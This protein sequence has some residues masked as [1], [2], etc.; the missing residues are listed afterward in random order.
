[1]KGSAGEIYIDPFLI[2]EKVRG[3]K[4]EGRYTEA[5]YPT[6][7]AE[8]VNGVFVHEMAHQINHSE[9]EYHAKAMTDL[10]GIL[11]GIGHTYQRRIRASFADNPTSH[12]DALERLHNQTKIYEDSNIA[13]TL[14]GIG[15]GERS[16]SRGN[17]SET[18]SRTS[19]EN[20]ERGYEGTEGESRKG[21]NYQESDEPPAN[22]LDFRPKPQAKTYVESRKTLEETLNSPE[23]KKQGVI[24][25][26]L[27][28]MDRRLPVF[29]SELDKLAT[30]GGEAGKYIAPHIKEALNKYDEF[31]GRWLNPTLATLKSHSVDDQNLI[32]GTMREENR[33]QV[34]LRDELP[35]EK[36]KESYDKIRQLLVDKQ[37]NQIE[38]NQPVDSY[39]KGKLGGFKT[40]PRLP[41]INKFYFPDIAGAKQLDII[42]NS[43]GSKAFD[44]LKR[45]FI[46]HIKEQ[47]KFDDAAAEQFFQDYRGSYSGNQGSGSRKFGAVNKAEG[48]GLPDSWLE[49]DAKVTMRRYW[50]RVSKARSWYDAVE[51]DHN[52]LHILNKSRDAWDEKVTPTVEGLGRGNQ[53]LTD[54]ID[55]IN[56][57]NIKT[58]PKL[59]ATVRIANNLLMGFATGV[60]DVISA[61]PVASK[62]LPSMFD[63][64]AAMGYAIKNLKRSIQH[65]TE[66]GRIKDKISDMQEIVNPSTDV[67]EKLRESA[68][69]V[70]KVT[71]REGLEKFS[72][73]LSQGINEYA[74]Q[75]HKKL[76]EL[77]DKKSIALLEDIANTS[78]WK[79]M[80]LKQLASRLVDRS[81]GTYDVRGLPNWV[82][83][84]QVSPLFR[85][86]KWNIEQL[87][88]LHKDVIMPA[89]RG[90]LTPLITTMV[91]GIAGGYIAKEVREA[92]N[93]KEFNGPNL[94]EIYKSKGSV[95]DKLHGSTY[96]VAAAISYSGVM[97]YLGELMKIGM[98]VSYKNKPHGLNFPTVEVISDM[99]DNISDAIQAITQ[100]GENPATVFPELAKRLITNNIQVG[101]IASNWLQ[102]KDTH[103][104]IRQRRDLR[105]YK[106]QAGDSYQGQT[107]TSNVN[108]YIGLETKKFQ[109]MDDIKEI[110]PE[111]RRLVKQTFQE[112]K[113]NPVELKSKMAKL[114]A[115]AVTTFPSVDS[116]PAEFKKYYNY[117]VDLHGPEEASKR[118]KEYF[119]KKNINN[120]RKSLIPTI[121]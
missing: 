115:G 15:R 82:I 6:A 67:V 83:N 11:E 61:M 26:N 117:L 19:A 108:P 89:T 57:T 69:F 14:V 3:S 96:A 41:R 72:R 47:Y 55:T 99:A 22:D 76:A 103:N 66:T 109:K 94:D 37:Q 5:E 114:K 44:I 17:D 118:M 111:S 100:E 4:A 21:K 95:G 16:S 85:M 73:G 74:V 92:I 32:V 51:K 56:G 116:A 107:S 58:N 10:A 29:G 88:N 71:G 79:S 81:Q 38:A 45:D 31:I 105:V 101:R 78:D 28:S 90:N 87:N 46:N 97:G 30:R 77:G 80:D 60:N 35:T 2:H 53:V 119:Q 13:D 113:G 106:Q 49:P 27:R 25:Q 112:N 43:E 24:R 40:I 65:A 18:S 20:I 9:G 63:S 93:H 121:R 86:M 91:T 23:F 98:D 110:I 50:S 42:L 120:V 64:P 62:Y 39:V 54:I 1:M 75:M 84:S 102:D 12:I 48:I 52:N 34:N 59:D 104:E 7:Y 36:L 8:A 70:A 68:D 33:R